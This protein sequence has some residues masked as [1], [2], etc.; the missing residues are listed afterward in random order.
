MLLVYH[1]HVLSCPGTSRP[2]IAE[3][4]VLF[5]YGVPA[6]K[7]NRTPV[8]VFAMDESEMAV[9]EIVHRREDRSTDGERRVV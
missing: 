1:L 9:T 4:D 6:R 8:D 7:F 3:L 2:D 5:E